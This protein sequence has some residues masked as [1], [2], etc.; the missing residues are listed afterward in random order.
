MAKAVAVVLASRL[1]SRAFLKSG[2]L[3]AVKKLEPYAE[4]IRARG[5]IRGTKAIGAAKGDAVPASQGWRVV[6]KIINTVTAAWDNREGAGTVA[7]PALQRA[8]D[9]ESKSMLDYIERKLRDGARR[10]GIRTN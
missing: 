9:F 6:A 1:R 10:A 3:W 2:W 8:I 7:T 4:K 5:P